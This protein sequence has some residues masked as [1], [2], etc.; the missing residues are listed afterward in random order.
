MQ[1]R[2]SIP[3]DVYGIR[4]VQKITWL[5]TYPNEKASITIGDIESVFKDDDAPEGKKKIE[6]RKE[7]YK[8]KSKQIWVAEKDDQIIGF[9]SAGKE[10]EKGR[11]LAIYVLPK[12]QGKGI[13][14]RLMA[15][16]LNWLVKSKKIYV[17]VVEYNL[18]TIMFYKK[19]GFSETGKR[20]VFDGAAALPSGKSLSE[21]EMVKTCSL[22]PWR[23]MTIRDRHEATIR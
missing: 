5:D 2:K 13:G 14:G 22:F 21:I 3:D 20:G 7:R 10:K 11:V 12:Y 23:P 8:D 6:A 4:R 1:I 16:A 19:F 17:N 18:K 9:C 15:E